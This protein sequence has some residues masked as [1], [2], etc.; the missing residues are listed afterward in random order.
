MNPFFLVPK[1][2]HKLL[3]KFLTDLQTCTVEKIHNNQQNFNYNM[4]KMQRMH[5]KKQKVLSY[6]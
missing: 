3:L 4:L 1:D 5:S 6:L 2:F